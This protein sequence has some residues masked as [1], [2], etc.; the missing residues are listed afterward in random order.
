ML[1]A[2]QD[3]ETALREVDSEQRRSAEIAAAVADA[4]TARALATT[5]YTRGLSDYFAVIDAQRALQASEDALASSRTA[6]MQHLV[7]LYKALGGGWQDEPGAPARAT[8]GRPPPRPA[9]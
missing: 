7:A 9:A 1:R 8:A 3:V 4:A 5:R 2:L 6:A